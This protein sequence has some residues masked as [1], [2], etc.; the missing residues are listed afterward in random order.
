ML[1]KSKFTGSPSG[2]KQRQSARKSVKKY[3]LHNLKN[4]FDNL[5]LD[6]IG[7]RRRKAEAKAGS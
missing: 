2:A 1:K 6:V 5:R 3:T 4:R 7:E